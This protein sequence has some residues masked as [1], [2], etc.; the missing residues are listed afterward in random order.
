MT[1]RSV[2]YKSYKALCSKHNIPMSK[3]W[4]SKGCSKDWLIKESAK[5]EEQHKSFKN[6]NETKKDDDVIERI[7]K[8]QREFE[9]ERERMKEKHRRMVEE[10]L[11]RALSSPMKILGLKHGFTKKDL[12]INYK[13][14]VLKHHPDKGGDAEMFKKINEAY[15]AFK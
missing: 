3:T 6:I 13:K 14:L 2:L 5:I 4:T 15:C 11:R 8:W 10:H 7:E 1:T 9:K 12:K